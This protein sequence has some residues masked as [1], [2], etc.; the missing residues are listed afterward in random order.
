MIFIYCLNAVTKKAFSLSSQ[1]AAKYASD[2]KS[3]T[4]IQYA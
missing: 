1:E 3:N 2:I 4:N